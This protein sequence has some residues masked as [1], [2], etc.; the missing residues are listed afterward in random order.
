MS[1]PKQKATGLGLN[2]TNEMSREMNRIAHSKQRETIKLNDEWRK[3]CQ[4]D[5]TL[6]YKIS[7]PEWRKKQ[8]RKLHYGKKANT[9][10]ST[11]PKS[12]KKSEKV[13][14]KT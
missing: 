1:A 9:K 3:L 8:L 7:F 12:G 4:E 13:P 2:P 14:S 5:P 10:G 11:R 6:P